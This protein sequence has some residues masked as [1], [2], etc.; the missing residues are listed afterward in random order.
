[1]AH[2]LI[3]RFMTEPIRSAVRSQPKA[4]VSK[5]KA[6]KNEPIKEP[7]TEEEMERLEEQ[8]R[9]RARIVAGYFGGA[10]AYG[11]LGGYFDARKE[12]L[13]F[14]EWRK[15]EDGYAKSEYL[16]SLSS[17]YRDTDLNEQPEITTEEQ[18]WNHG[19]HR[20]LAERFEN[21]LMWPFDLPVTLLTA[22]IPWAYEV[23][24]GTPSSTESRREQ[25]EKEFE[26]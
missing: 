13:K 21:S 24:A 26:E 3:R 23:I 17:P 14:R 10:V 6:P 1:M 4:E 20:H 9:Q 2:R 19:K 16:Q 25:L 12:V 8:M 15:R 7:Q 18:A 22:G 5:G 11:W